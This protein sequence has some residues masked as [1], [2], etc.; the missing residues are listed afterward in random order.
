MVLSNAE[1]VNAPT[2][3]RRVPRPKL[4][5]KDALAA[6]YD[7]GAV[8]KFGRQ[9]A[10]VLKMDRGPQGVRL[11]P[12]FNVRTYCLR[13]KHRRRDIE[14]IGLELYALRRKH[15]E[16]WLAGEDTQ[17]E[18]RRFSELAPL[19]DVP[20][21]CG[22]RAQAFERRGKRLLN[23]VWQL[24]GCVDYFTHVRNGLW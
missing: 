5:D 17:S 16:K 21:V 18:R 7:H 8:L 9:K 23:P 15:D 11:F 14:K 4:A 20:C 2:V 24:G 12:P 6:F 19:F 22:G 10:R 13:C 3:V 1:R